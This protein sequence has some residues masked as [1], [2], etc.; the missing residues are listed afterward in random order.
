MD[1]EKMSLCCKALGDETRFQ[2]FQM[3][4]GGKLCACKILKKFSIT[5]PTLSY[6]MKLLCECGLVS[7]EKD[8][9]WNHYSVNFDVLKELTE[10][11]NNTN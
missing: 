6:H 5:Q 2:I 7:A 3:L 1:F 9:T 4:K 10:T 11:L 8:G